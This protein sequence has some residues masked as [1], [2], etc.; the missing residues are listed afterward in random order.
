MTLTW[1]TTALQPAAIVKD[2]SAMAGLIVDTMMVAGLTGKIT[3]NCPIFED[4]ARHYINLTVSLYYSEICKGWVQEN[5]CKDFN[6]NGGQVSIS[7]I[8]ESR[9]CAW[10]CCFYQGVMI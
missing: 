3:I 9:E 2:L 1:P 5:V 10:S 7:E 4:K 8:N 6:W